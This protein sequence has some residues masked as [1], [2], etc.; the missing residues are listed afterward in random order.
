MSS[1]RQGIHTKTY[2]NGATYQGYYLNDKR[3]GAGIKTHADGKRVPCVYEHGVK[4][5]GTKTRFMLELDLQDCEALIK[6]AVGEAATQIEDVMANLKVRGNCPECGGNG[7]LHGDYRM[8]WNCRT[9]QDKGI[10]SFINRESKELTN[11]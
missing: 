4:V 9:C 11:D 1:K 5:L 3:H 6:G 7:Q 10:P 8:D 2:P